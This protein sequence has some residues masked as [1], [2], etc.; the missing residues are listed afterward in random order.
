MVPQYPLKPWGD[1]PS[2]LVSCLDLPVFLSRYYLSFF[3]FLGNGLF[4][5]SLCDQYVVS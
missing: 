3:L 4:L 5:L 1:L 2:L